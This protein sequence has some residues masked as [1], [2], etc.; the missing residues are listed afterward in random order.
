MRV[1]A[2]IV[3]ML[4]RTIAARR[5]HNDYWYGQEC[6]S[7]EKE[8]L[9]QSNESHGYFIDVLEKVRDILRPRMPADV[10]DNIPTQSSE[11]G[12]SGLTNIFDVLD[13][14][15]PTLPSQVLQVEEADQ[16]L[17]TRQTQTLHFTV[18][19]EPDLGEVYFAVDCFFNDLHNIRQY[20][21]QVWD[22][23]HQDASDL[24]AASLV[25]NTAIE[26][27]RGIEEDFLKTFPQHADFE[28]HINFMYV[29]A[30]LAAGS[31]PTYKERQDDEMNFSV[32]GAV[33]RTLFPTFML[34][35]SFG[36]VIQPGDV[37]IY[38]PGHYGTYDAKSDRDSKAARAKFR[39]DKVVLLQIL[40]EFCLIASLTDIFPAEDEMIRGMRLM[41]SKKPVTMWL[42]FAAQI[43]LDVNHILRDTVIRGL[44]DLQRNAKFIEN[45]I[46]QV[47]EFHE[48][49][50]VET[51]PRS[52]DKALVEIS[53]LIKRYVAEDVVQNARKRM[54]NFGSLPSPEP[55]FLLRQ[56]PLLCGL[57]CFKVKMLM[58]E[59]SITFVNAWGS[60]LYTA[61]LYN[62]VRQEKLLV[63]NWKDMDL[64]LMLHRTQDMFIGALPTTIDDYLKRFSLA[65]GYSAASFASNRRPKKGVIA[66]KAGPRGL[67]SL[68]PV[69]NMFRRRFIEDDSTTRFSPE[70]VETVLEKYAED[71]DIDDVYVDETGEEWTTPQI[72]INF[73]R[74]PNLTDEQKDAVAK[75]HKRQKKMKSITSV[76]D[77]VRPIQL[78]NALLNELQSETLE[79]TFDHFRL[80]TF[81]WRLLRAVQ[82]ELDED[83]KRYF[84]AGYLEKENQLPFVIGYIFMTATSTKQVAALLAP[85]RQADVTSRLLQK[86]AKTVETMIEN[87]A[88][89]I[90]CGMMKQFLD[91]DI[92][93]P[94]V[95]T[96]MTR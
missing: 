43:F 91:M 75:L 55:F 17:K 16:T 45:S 42:T 36:N 71:D 15:E 48:D 32:Y 38:K 94:D 8:A 61:H 95:I 84:R 73:N 34:L 30:C 46:S 44:Y 24:V 86:A 65:M 50:R 76:K 72:K 52:N 67:N 89:E 87:G 81:C 9:K 74:D 12:L 22:G 80:H 33:E 26:F 54:R 79:L 47:L 83:L 3:A 29:R 13:V 56:H 28:K 90:V 5:Q 70:D 25:T 64:A 82:R 40:P 35:S 39:E 4:D 41:V 11:N 53:D 69:S 58:Q 27:V 66:S 57:I 14:S 10:L 88:G 68:S 20:L 6:D 93:V 19:E 23:Y 1:P 92:D 78:L 62:A 18:Q 51:W 31:D 63:R 85:K 49:L 60:V 7:E 77:G 2:D 37:P 96:D 59:A 21:R